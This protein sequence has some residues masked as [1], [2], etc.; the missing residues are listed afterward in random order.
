MIIP[1]R[2]GE[3]AMSQLSTL[4]HHSV[5]VV[6]RRFCAEKLMDNMEHPHRV[7]A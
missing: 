6:E 5:E 4:H 2:C 7:T 1:A 3:T